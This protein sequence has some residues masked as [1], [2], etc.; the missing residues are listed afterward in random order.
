MSGP[1]DTKGGKIPVQAVASTTTTLKRYTLCSILGIATGD[2]P[3]ADD[4]P[5][6]PPDTV[7]PRRNN[8]MVTALRKRG[9]STAEASELVGGRGPSQ[10]TAADREEIGL[11]L[12]AQQTPATTEAPAREPGEEG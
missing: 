5:Q 6:E 11:W 12:R 7:D 4:A 8:A 3:D 10:W 1:P 2:M 9:R